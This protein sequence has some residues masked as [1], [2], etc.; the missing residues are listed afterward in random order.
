MIKH[1]PADAADRAALRSNALLVLGYSNKSKKWLLV[2][3][4][5]RRIQAGQ[6]ALQDGGSSLPVEAMP[7]EGNDRPPLLSYCLTSQPSPRWGWQEDLAP[8]GS[9][10][11]IN[12]SR[13]PILIAMVAWSELMWLILLRVNG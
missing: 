4:E 7:P 11:K 9:R 2:T 3:E 6:T 13:V 10:G 1:F 8:I 5:I 12:E